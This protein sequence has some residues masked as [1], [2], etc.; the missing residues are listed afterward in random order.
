MPEICPV[1]GAPTV[2]VEGEA[3]VRCTGIECP[4]QLFRS[5]VH[6]TSRDAMNIE[7]LGPAIVDQ[8]LEEKLVSNIADLYYLKFEDLFK[9]ERMGKKSSENLLNSINKSKQNSL[10]KL[11]FGF[12]IRY[13]GLRAAQLLA[14]GFNSLDEIMLADVQRFL[15][16]DEIGDKMAESVVKFFSQEQTLH[17]I[18]RLKEAGVNMRG[19][20]K[21][22]KDA[23]FE[24]LTFVLTGTL[25]NYSRHKVT[26]IIESFGGKVSGSVSKK[27]SYVLS[28]DE[29]GSK[30]EKAHQLGVKVIEEKEFKELID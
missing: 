30:L 10:D 15:Q 20:K 13:I 23:R 5:I 1:C 6:F 29:A 24:G 25:E 26:E 18:D 27:T 19:S 9:L 28:G 7:G 17:T 14:Q 2:R 12:G 16:I 11:I 4:A 22:I 21:K 8:L 3:A